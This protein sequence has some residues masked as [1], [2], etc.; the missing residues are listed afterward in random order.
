MVYKSVQ[1]EIGDPIKTSLRC[2][3]LIA[4]QYDQVI[5]PAAT[6]CSVTRDLHTFTRSFK[7]IQI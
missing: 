5:I 3:G 4:D 2:P 6:E 7:Q 1:L